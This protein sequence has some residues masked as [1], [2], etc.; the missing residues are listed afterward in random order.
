MASFQKKKKITRSTNEQ[1]CMADS[2]ERFK[3]TETVNPRCTSA[4]ESSI[5]NLDTRLLMQD[6]SPVKG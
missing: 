3:L 1:E 2:K 5:N 4:R 6:P